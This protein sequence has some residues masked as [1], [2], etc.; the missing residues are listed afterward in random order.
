MAAKTVF[1]W[2]ERLA[3]HLAVTKDLSTAESLAANS[4][5]QMVGST[6]IHSVVWKVTSLAESSEISWADLTGVPRA[7]RWAENLAS[8]T[9]GWWGDSMAAAMATNW[10]ALWGWRSAATTDEHLAVSTDASKAANSATTWVECL[11]AS[12]A[13]LTSLT[14]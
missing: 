6:E 5:C 10:A 2:A 13:G 7:E 3:G 8:L 12:M 11:A 9:A 14:G 1:C 4:D